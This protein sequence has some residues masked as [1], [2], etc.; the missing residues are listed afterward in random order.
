MSRLNWKRQQQVHLP[1]YDNPEH[2]LARLG[3]PVKER[4]AK[5]SPTVLA[6]VDWS[7]S[8]LVMEARDRLS[9]VTRAIV[10]CDGSSQPNPGRG[11]WG[12]VI[13]APPLPQIE[14]SGGEPRTTNN[15]MEMT[16]AIVALTVL[17]IR[18][19]T[20]LITDSQYLIK[21]ATVWLA[22]WKRN[23]YERTE[24]PVLNA[25]LWRSIDALSTGRAITWKWIRGHNG[26]PGNERADQL[27]AKG[28]TEAISN[29]W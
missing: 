19:S 23:N 15:R 21:G 22:G 6:Q 5:S 1:W 8:P 16:A 26:H 28:R 14:L 2:D 7:S 11:G 12:V 29:A 9:A 25:D 17:Q 27:A 24:G 3:V 10:H 18:C 13:D 4:N 20:S